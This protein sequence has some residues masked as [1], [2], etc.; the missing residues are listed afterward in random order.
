MDNQL[1]IKIILITLFVLFGIALVLPV[2]G[3]RRLA[4]RR[5]LLVFVTIGGIVAISFPD[6]LNGVANLVGVGR[7]TDLVLYVLVVVFIGNSI[8]SSIRHRQLEREMTMLAR[9][10]AISGAPSPIALSC[11]RAASQDDASESGGTQ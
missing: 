9:N 3:A 2:T 11:S 10:I 4:I 1:V 7:G 6:L 5:L 8:A